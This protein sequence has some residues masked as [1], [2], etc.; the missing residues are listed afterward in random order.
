[1]AQFFRRRHTEAAQRDTLRV[2]HAH[3]VAGDA[4]LA[5]GVEALDD[6]E[7]VAVAAGAA[8]GEE[9]L[10]QLGEQLAAGGHVLLSLC[11]VAVPTGG[12]GAVEGGEVEVW[13]GLEC[14]PRIRCPE[15]GH[16]CSPFAESPQSTDARD[17]V[18]LVG[19]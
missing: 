1:M 3:D 2:H 18:G 19:V 8:V 16:G 7:D 14:L 5:R 10:L 11:L 12:A 13:A 9:S 15:V 17:A 6:D 4:A